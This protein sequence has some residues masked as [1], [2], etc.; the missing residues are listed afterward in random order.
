MIAE[1]FDKLSILIIRVIVS[2]ADSSDKLLIKN[3]NKELKKIFLKKNIDKKYIFY[4]NL[5]V[6]VNYQIWMLKEKMYK[7]NGKFKRMSL[8]FLTK[9]IR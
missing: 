5:L 6:Q 2:K 7:K 3:I 4:L 1:L 9:L 8:N